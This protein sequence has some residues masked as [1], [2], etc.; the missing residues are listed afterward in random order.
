MIFSATAQPV[1]ESTDIFSVLALGVVALICGIPI[2]LALEKG[3][4]LDDLVA[5]L[6]IS[7]LLGFVT[8]TFVLPKLVD[9]GCTLC[10]L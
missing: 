10:Q 3:A 1:L 6:L 5:A 4:E 7:V 2:F 9:L 8:F